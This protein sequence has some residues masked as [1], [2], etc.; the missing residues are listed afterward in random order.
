[1]ELKSCDYVANVC[2]VVTQPSQFQP[3][4]Q[5]D[6]LDSTIKRNFF[7]LVCDMGQRKFLSVLIEMSAVSCKTCFFF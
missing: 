5:A 2:S 4:V 3:L 1:M 7:C 6:H